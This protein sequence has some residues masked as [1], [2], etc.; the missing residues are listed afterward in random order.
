MSFG[1]HLTSAHPERDV[2]NVGIPTTGR[3]CNSSTPWAT[4]ELHD[5]NEGGTPCRPPFCHVSI[6]PYIVRC[7]WQQLNL[8]A[9]L[10]LSDG[11]RSSSTPQVILKLHGTAEKVPCHRAHVAIPSRWTPRT[12]HVPHHFC[13]WSWF[14]SCGVIDH[15]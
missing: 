8:H 4:I 6:D 11:P 3:P 2:I 7:L 15:Y 13:S 12:W 14:R 10:E 1:V 9:T 5:P